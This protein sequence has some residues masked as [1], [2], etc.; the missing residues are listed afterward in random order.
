MLT[1]LCLKGNYFQ[2]KSNLYEQEEG[3]A[4]G[5]PISLIFAKFFMQKLEET[6]VSSLQ[7]SLYSWWRYVDDVFTIAKIQHIDKIQT[8][9][10]NFHPTTLRMKSWKITNSHF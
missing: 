7:S 3:A 9:L 8:T 4:M 2:F 10:N 5:N 6:V 1:E